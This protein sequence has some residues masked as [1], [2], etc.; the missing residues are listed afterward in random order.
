MF[1]RPVLTGAAK[2]SIGRKRYLPGL[3]NRTLKYKNT[4]PF[5]S[6]NLSTYMDQIPVSGAFL[7]PYLPSYFSQFSASIF[8][9]YKSKTESSFRSN[10]LW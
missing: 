5:Y 2:E 3:K 6:R 10:E 8:I 9:S 1:F 4:I 7:I